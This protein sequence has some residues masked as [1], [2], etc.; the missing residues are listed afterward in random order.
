MWADVIVFIQQSGQS[1]V[2]VLQ[3]I[4]QKLLAQ[5]AVNQQVDIIVTKSALAGEMLT[6]KIA[7]IELNIRAPFDVQ[8]G[9]KLQIELLMEEGKPVLKL[10]TP[11]QTQKITV[12]VDSLAKMM[13]MLPSLKVGQQVAVEV[14]KILAE[15]RLLV[16]TVQLNNSPKLPTQA[17]QQFDIDISQLSKSYKQGDKLLMD[18]VNTNPLAIKLRPESLV[19]REQIVSDRIRQLLPQ[20][21]TSPSLDKVLTAS[22]NA[23]LPPAIQNAV[24]QLVQNITEQ[25]HLTQSNSLKHALA[26]S[27]VFTESRLLKVPNENT[28]DFKANISRVLS[29]LETVISQVQT[30]LNGKP[31]NKLPAQVEAAL[32]ANG[33]TPAQLLNV[34][35]SGKSTATPN[36]FAQSVFS[37]ITT[38]EQANALIQLLTKSISNQQQGAATSRQ[39]PIAMAELLILFKEVEG[40]HNKLQHN[41]LSMLKEPESSNV[42]A[43]WLFDLPIKDKQN[44]DL[45]QVQIEQQKKQADKGEESWQVQLRLDTQNLGPV[46]ASV[47]L[48][49]ENVNVVIRAEKVESAELLTENLPLL[50]AALEKLDV[51]IK[52]MSCVCGEVN[53]PASRSYYQAESSDLVDISV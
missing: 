19:S 16:Q 39:A 49:G 30:E 23:Q 10:L 8:A 4:P 21:L 46:Q 33:K 36:S 12:A 31:I 35:L 38:P 42:A 11:D 47:T 48:N 24:Q 29:S 45:L 17:A 53:K 13:S 27:G 5:M 25:S 37:A 1:P 34:L 7:D 2:A 52:H 44:I 40:I 26:S 51:S 3:D 41:Q 9:Q 28:Q 20:L 22:N 32:L 50:N 6:I 14:V 18:I 15:N 43:S